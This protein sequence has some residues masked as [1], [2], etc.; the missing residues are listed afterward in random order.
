LREDVGRCPHKGVNEKVQT[1]GFSVKRGEAK[2]RKGITEVRAEDKKDSKQHKRGEKVEVQMFISMT[3]L[4]T[5]LF[6]GTSQDL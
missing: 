5:R 6:K 2:A 3:F 4:F 1:S